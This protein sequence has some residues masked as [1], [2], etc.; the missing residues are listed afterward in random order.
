VATREPAS[1]MVLET[2]SE[3]QNRDKGPSNNNT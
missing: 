2:P 1:Q 3:P